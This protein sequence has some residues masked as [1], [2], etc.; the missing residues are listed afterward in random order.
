M[1]V[2]R[3]RALW[4]HWV[5]P[6]IASILDWETRRRRDFWARPC[7]ESGLGLVEDGGRR[8]RV[9][10][11]WLAAARRFALTSRFLGAETIIRRLPISLERLFASHSGALAGGWPTDG[12]LQASAARCRRSVHLG[13]RAKQT[14]V[15]CR[16]VNLCQ[17]EAESSAM[18]T[19]EPLEDMQPPPLEQRGA[20]QG[21]AE[22]EEQEIGDTSARA[23]PAAGRSAAQI[24]RSLAWLRPTGLYYSNP[25]MLHR[26][27]KR[28]HACEAHAAS[29]KR[30]AHRS[31]RPSHR[32][33]PRQQATSKHARESP[34]S[35]RR[36]LTTDRRARAAAAAFVVGTPCENC[37]EPMQRCFGSGR[38]CGQT[39]ASKFSRV[40]RAATASSP[41]GSPGAGKKSA[42]VGANPPQ[43]LGRVQVH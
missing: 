6:G 2:V 28:R 14:P 32:S 22:D 40:G 19:G 16:R 42:G 41:Q 17:L 37:S 5:A 15:R 23:V 30:A 31:P 33:P 21:E 10:N 20:E 34:K 18:A 1:G 26:S 4:R 36:P 35:A 27:R 13:A 9:A 3:L 7:R 24:V 12:W 11:Q 39:C 38:F 8:G 29:A 25:E 43:A